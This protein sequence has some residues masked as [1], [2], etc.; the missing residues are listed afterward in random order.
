MKHVQ[1][2]ATVLDKFIKRTRFLNTICVAISK[3]EVEFISLS[4]LQEV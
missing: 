2:F 4:K 3:H 1:Y